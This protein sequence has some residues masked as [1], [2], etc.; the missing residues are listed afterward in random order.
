M[1]RGRG[2]QML[3]KLNKEIWKYLLKQQITITAEYF[4][5]SLNVEADW[6]PRNGRTHHKGHSAKKY[7]N[8][9]ASRLSHQLPQY[10]VWKLDPFSQG[11]DALEQNWGNQFL[12]AIAPFC[13]I[14]QVLKKVSYDQTEKM[15]LVTPTWQSQ[16]W[17]IVR[18]LLLPRNASLI[19]SGN[20]SSNCKQNI[21]NSG[22]D[23]IE[24]RLLKKG[25]W[26]TAALLI[27]SKRRKSS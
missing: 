25:V 14:L 1:G 12:Y 4:P 15:L 23:H 24:E 16:I 21:T 13:L 5:S 20:S 8:K 11:A 19:T 17:S 2:D 27:A 10:F 3:L 7:F 18:P 22:L 9:S 6:Q 26:E